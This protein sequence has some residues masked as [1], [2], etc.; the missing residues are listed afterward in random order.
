VNLERPEAGLFLAESSVEELSEI[1]E[2][3]NAGLHSLSETTDG[4]PRVPA[5]SGFSNSEKT[6]VERPVIDGPRPLWP[7][8]RIHC[9]FVEP[10]EVHVT[11]E[12][13]GEFLIPE[14]FLSQGEDSVYFKEG[15]KH[16]VIKP[17]FFAL[18]R[19]VRVLR[20]EVGIAVELDLCIQDPEREAGDYKALED[21]CPWQ[22][23]D[24]LKH[25]GECRID[26]ETC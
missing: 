18:D 16:V 4:H 24:W 26:V 14:R 17:E 12:R 20:D 7:G 25:K 6:P 9:K 13:D 10:D 15:T 5:K 19:I 11:F 2:G 22:R 3:E 1:S 8:D 21:P 23:P